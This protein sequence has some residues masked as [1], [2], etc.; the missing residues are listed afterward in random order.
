MK[1]SDGL[2]IISATKPVT[3]I[4]TASDCRLGKVKEPESC[5]AAKAALRLKGCTEARVHLGRTY[6]KIGRKWLKYMTPDS[7]RSEIVAFDRGGS[8]SPGEYTLRPIPD[9]IRL[10]EGK[11]KSFGAPKKGRPGYHRK[12]HVISGV[13]HKAMSVQD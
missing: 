9:S 12:H 4:I 8:F 10:M 2:P 13:R 3:I 5:A 6:L 11:A 7:L 1:M